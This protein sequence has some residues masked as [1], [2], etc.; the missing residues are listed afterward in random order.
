MRRP[1]R[2]LPLSFLLLVFLTYDLDQPRATRALS[3]EG[4]GRMRRGP[5][6]VGAMQREGWNTSRVKVYLEFLICRVV[7]RFSGA[8]RKL[9]TEVETFMEHCAKRWQAKEGTYQLKRRRLLPDVRDPPEQGK[10]NV[11]M[12]DI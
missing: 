8:R 1:S 2:V 11:D 9:R 5:D 10:A 12:M 4:L 6:M 3:E 7:Y